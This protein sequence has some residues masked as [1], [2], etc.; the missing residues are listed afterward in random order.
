MDIGNPSAD[1]KINQIAVETKIVMTIASLRE[2]RM[3]LPTVLLTASP[4]IRAPVIAKI[5][6]K[7]AVGY[8]LDEIPNDITKETPASFEP[9][10]DYCVVK[11]PRWAFEK[12]SR[13]DSTL[14]TSMKSVGEVM[15]IGRSFEESIQKSIRMLDVGMNGLI[16]NKIKFNDLQQELKEPTD[17]RLFA[18]VEAIKQGFSIDEIY[19]LSNVNPWFLYKIKNVVEIEKQLKKFKEIPS[20]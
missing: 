20:L 9:A 15:A 6:A 1:D 4:K 10:I 17:K 13:A 14:T 3:P 7:L 8:T 11:I 19:N 16:C 2:T 12:F 5:A 18:I